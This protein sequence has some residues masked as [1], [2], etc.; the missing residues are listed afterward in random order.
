LLAVIKVAQFMVVQ[1]V[2]ERS[3]LLDKDGL[4]G[5]SVYKSDDGSS[6]P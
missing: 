5:D 2:L 6:P 4:D 1:Q 3:G